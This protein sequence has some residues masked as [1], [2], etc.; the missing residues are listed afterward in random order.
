MTSTSLYTAA[1]GLMAQ[2]MRIDVIANNIANSTTNGFKRSDLAFKDLLYKDQPRV[3]FNSSSADTVTPTGVQVGLGVAPSG[4]FRIHT[5]GSLNVTDAPLDLAVKG[6]GYFVI[7]L[8]TG[9]EAYTR[10]GSFQRNQDGTIVNFNG[11]EVA[12]SITI[13]NDTI[14]LNINKNGEV[15]VIQQN[16]PTPTQLGQID[17]V[18]F[19]NEAGLKSIGDNL[20]VE[21]EAS[22]PALTGVPGEEGFGEIV[23]GSVELSNVEPV[24]ET[25]N[26]IK[27]QRAF[28]M[29]SNIVK[30]SDE[31]LQTL[32]GMKR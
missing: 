22:G 25:V 8:P 16:N 7:Q 6:R 31:V 28:E 24:V 11:Y 4:A 10:D 15:E 19:V 5:Q 18:T 20:Y 32:N 14:E 21:T 17:M 13:P 2:Q 26:L 27:A 3:G 9:E 1:T 12:P 30:V 23:Q 29:N